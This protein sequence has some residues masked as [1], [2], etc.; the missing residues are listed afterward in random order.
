MISNPTNFNHVAHM[1]PGDGMQVLMDLPLVSPTRICQ[2]FPH[3]S[4]FW[5]HL[6]HGP[7]WKSQPRDSRWPGPPLLPLGAGS[8]PLLVFHGVTSCQH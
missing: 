7:W 6:A 1:G 3:P 2:R 4:A 5:E 8:A